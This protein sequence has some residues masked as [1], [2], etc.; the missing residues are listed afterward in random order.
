MWHIHSVDSHG[1]VAREWHHVR[2]SGVLIRNHALSWGVPST[3]SDTLY[4][5]K[6]VRVPFNA[7]KMLTMTTRPEPRLVWRP[8]FLIA[9]VKIT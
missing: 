2:V 5:S 1:D 6:S 8:R 7:Q 3:A 4:E 9:K